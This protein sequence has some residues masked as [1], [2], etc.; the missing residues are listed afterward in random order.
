MK[1]IRTCLELKNFILDFVFPPHCLL[2][3]RLISSEEGK[4]NGIRPAGLVCQDCWKSLNVLPHPFCPTCRTFFK[5]EYE[6]MSK[7]F[8]IVF[9]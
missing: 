6:E 3:N 1:I 4:Y 2:C 5:P 8:R 9:S 7:M